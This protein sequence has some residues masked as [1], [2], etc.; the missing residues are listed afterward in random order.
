[1]DIHSTPPPAQDFALN[2][3]GFNGEERS[4]FKFQS[5]LFHYLSLSTNMCPL[6]W[7]HFP[8]PMWPASN[9]P[10]QVATTSHLNMLPSKILLCICGRTLFGGTI[11]IWPKKRTLIYIHKKKYRHSWHHFL[12]PKISLWVKRW[13]TLGGFSALNIQLGLG[14]W[15]I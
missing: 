13:W 5:N 9:M 12:F 14:G 11:C 6:K 3:S 1:M 15:Y 8:K 7:L 10:F 4:N 2:Q